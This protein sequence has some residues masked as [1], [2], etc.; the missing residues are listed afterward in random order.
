MILDVDNYALAIAQKDRNAFAAWM[1]H[2]ESPLRL[3]LATFARVVDTES[4]LQETLIR[5]WNV[6]PHFEP[7]GKPNGLF[8]LAVR[9]G[10][11]LA[12]S[13]LRKRKHDAA[14][15]EEGREA[16]GEWS[17][18]DPMLKKKIR[19]C[20]GA[21]PD[22]PRNVLLARLQSAGGDAD[23]VLADRLRMKLNTFLQNFTRARKFIAECLK[24]AGIDVHAELFT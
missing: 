14:P 22:A 5:V 21:L 8:R 1:S 3:S 2:C 19:E 17:P 7:D 15:Y 12:I 9:I 20:Y 23:E 4:V 13:E 16:G 24:K 11:N 10:R 6:A 18:P